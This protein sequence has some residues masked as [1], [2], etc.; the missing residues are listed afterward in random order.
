[1]D[2]ET[3]TNEHVLTPEERAAFLDEAAAPVTV[4]PEVVSQVPVVEATPELSAQKVELVDGQTQQTVEAPAIVVKPTETTPVT[5]SSPNTEPELPEWALELHRR[6]ER[7]ETELLMR[8]PQQAAQQTVQPVSS[9]TP[10][11]QDSP[12]PSVPELDALFNLDPESVV[13]IMS[14]PKKFVEYQKNLALAAVEAGRKSAVESLRTETARDYQQRIEAEQAKRAADE[15][16][17]TTYTKHPEL[18][19]FDVDVRRYGVELF[20]QYSD[21]N[22]QG[23]RPANEAEFID[24]LGAYARQKLRIRKVRGADAPP[25]VLGATGVHALAKKQLTEEE[26]MAYIQCGEPLP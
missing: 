9:S 14:D 23:K 8:Q 17:N 22:Y 13:E 20:G 25:P 18:K 6:N 21:P 15:F 1:M 2:I 16:W 12:S 3:N 4:V 24:S 11:V 7:L 19:N 5:E 10:V 26:R